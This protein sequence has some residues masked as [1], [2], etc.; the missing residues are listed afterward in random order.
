VNNS[1]NADNVLDIARSTLTDLQSVWLCITRPS[2]IQFYI[3]WDLTTWDTPPAKH[4]PAVNRLLTSKTS[5]QWRS[6]T[7]IYDFH[8]LVRFRCRPTHAFSTT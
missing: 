8:R 2:S 5:L 4:A 7:A 6:Y 3:A 1:L